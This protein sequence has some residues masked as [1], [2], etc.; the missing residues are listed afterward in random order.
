MNASTFFMTCCLVVLVLVGQY[1]FHLQF[2]LRSFHRWLQEEERVS[3]SGSG[4]YVD[5]AYLDGSS[6]EVVAND[7]QWARKFVVFLRPVRQWWYRAMPAW[8]HV[9]SSHL[10][11]KELAF[12][13]NEV[14]T[15]LRS[16]SPIQEAW[17][18]SW[19]RIRPQDPP[20]RFDE[21][22]LPSF[23]HGPESSNESMGR[24]SQARGADIPV[25]V[26]T[27][28]GLRM[29]LLALRAA[30]I[31]SAR[32][33][34]PLADILDR[35]ASGIDDVEV[36]ANAR[37]VACAGARTSIRILTALPFIAVGAGVFLG[38]DPL[39]HFLDGSI[40]SI[41]C[42]M[43]LVL[44]VVGHLL[45]RFLLH[46]AMVGEDMVDVAILCDLAKA[47][48]DSGAALPDV[49]EA[50]GHAI[51]DSPLVQAARE[52]R[53]GVSWRRATAQCDKRYL[54]LIRGLAIAWEDG[55]SPVPLLER[56]AGQVRARRT[57]ESKLEAE[58]LGVRVVIPVS[59]CLLPAFVA[60]GLL[61]LILHF[62]QTGLGELIAGT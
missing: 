57:V 59:A 53:L 34:A 12:L 13:C 58:K 32:L 7:S 62:A 21:L 43:G 44:M 17:Q 15:R 49:M 23:L 36:A 46:R 24:Q 52:L 8:L 4:T 31:F 48:L 29:E 28:G 55:A 26:S 54:P 35:I 20:L 56:S 42:V 6:D 41:A 18:R 37:S 25:Q 27:N 2:Q 16:G 3:I 33:G 22:G 50:L 51:A 38:V 9:N 40:G 10:D 60:L 61:P 30:C 1:L 47:G 14:A 11:D 45:F 5:D 39:H 19:G